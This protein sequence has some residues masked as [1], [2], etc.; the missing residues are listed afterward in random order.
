VRLMLP[1]YVGVAALGAPY[2][3]GTFVVTEDWCLRANC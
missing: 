1:L 2:H 3:G